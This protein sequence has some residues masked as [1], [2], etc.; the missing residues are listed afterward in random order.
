MLMGLD[1][2]LLECGDADISDIVPE[3]DLMESGAWFVGTTWPERESKITTGNL[4]QLD[5]RINSVIKSTA[6]SSALGFGNG[7]SALARCVAV[8]V[9]TR[10]CQHYD[11]DTMR[12]VTHSQSS[13][14]SGYVLVIPNK[15]TAAI[16]HCKRGVLQLGS[17]RTHAYRRLMSQRVLTRSSL[18]SHVLVR[19]SRYGSPRRRYGERFLLILSRK[20]R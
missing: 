8:R 7:V 11:A 2:H 16:V 9:L 19:E 20:Q 1:A 4:G 15:C 13:K 10:A 14:E 5:R 18:T 6:I 3:G 17:M 12:R